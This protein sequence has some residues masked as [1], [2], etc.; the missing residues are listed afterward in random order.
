MNE[1]SAV[2]VFCGASMGAQSVYEKAAIAMGK[3]LGRR[4]LA[5]VYGGGSVGL[6][7]V[8]ART[9]QKSG[10]SVMGVIP[11]SLTGRE[12]MGDQIGELIVVETTHERKAIM[13]SMSDAFVALPGGFGTLDE[14]FEM[15]TWAQ[16]GIH[17]KPVG[18]LNVAG[19]FDPL[20]QWV[21]RGIEQGFIRS[22]YRELM[23]ADNEPAALLDR[24][25][26]HTLPPGLVQ[27]LSLEDA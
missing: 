5:L 1:L 17:A 27:W 6:M 7:S 20:L 26:V 8:L 15:V 24:L 11:A 18:L 4:R 25:Q 14:L 3:E 13:A 19:Y 10:C 21:D 23:L 12:L 9:A 16:L 2:C 22:R